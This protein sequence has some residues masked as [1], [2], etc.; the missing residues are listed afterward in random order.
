MYARV[1]HKK[2]LYAMQYVFV[3][4]FWYQLEEEKQGQI[5]EVRHIEY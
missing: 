3:S 2:E 1:K 5:I 4:D